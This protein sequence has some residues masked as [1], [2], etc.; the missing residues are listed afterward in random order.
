MEERKLF[1]TNSPLPL[2]ENKVIQSTRKGHQMRLTGG[3]NSQWQLLTKHW[4]LLGKYHSSTIQT[5]VLSDL[6][7]SKKHHGQV[8]WFN[9]SQLLNP[10][11]PLP[12]PPTMGWGNGSEQ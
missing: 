3:L 7:S 12:P 5:G 2:D 1:I 6:K 10:T 4:N 11:Q 8:S 9:P